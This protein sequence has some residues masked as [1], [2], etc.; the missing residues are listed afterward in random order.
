MDPRLYCFG[1]G[2]RYVLHT[3]IRHLI[4]DGT[5]AL[6]VARLTRP[7][8]CPGRH[9]V[10]VSLYLAITTILATSTILKPVDEN[11]KEY[12]PEVRFVGPRF[13]YVIKPQ[14]CTVFSNFHG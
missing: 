13:E 5:R 4:T 10:D 2:R 9:F 3:A 1:V 11:G 12:M 7:R 8:I 6:A 14:N